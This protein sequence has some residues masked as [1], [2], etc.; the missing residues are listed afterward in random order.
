MIE[1][2]LKDLMKYE[3]KS[4][5][6]I[7]TLIV[8]TS[9]DGGQ[10]ID[11]IV[12]EKYIRK[13]D[14]LIHKINNII[15]DG[16]IMSKKRQTVQ[17]K[18]SVKKATVSA[19]VILSKRADTENGLFSVRARTIKYVIIEK[20]LCDLE[21]FG[22]RNIESRLG[23]I[24]NELGLIEKDRDNVGIIRKIY[25]NKLKRLAETYNINY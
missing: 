7:L 15:G 20:E 10:E 19:L 24:L 18:D 8:K 5:V 23:L 11:W 6:R 13:Y 14:K 12:L 9:E 21:D 22:S 4:V 17:M 25:M 16:F 3:T 1:K 2:Q